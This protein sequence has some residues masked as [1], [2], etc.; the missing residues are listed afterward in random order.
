MQEARVAVGGFIISGGDAARVFQLVEATLDAVSQS[1]DELID[2]DLHLASAAH[3][4][5]GDAAFGFH[6]V[7]NAIGVI[8]LVGDQHFGFRPFGVHHDVVA[9]VVRDFAAGDFRRDREPFAG[10]A[11]MNFCRKATF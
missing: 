11:E 1:V 5:D 2:S 8:A 9:L 3:R 6:V 4:N 10:D 7:A